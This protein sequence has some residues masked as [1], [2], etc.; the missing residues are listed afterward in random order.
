MKKPD[1]KSLSLTTAAIRTALS[2]VENLITGVTKGYRCVLCMRIFRSML[3]LL[4][5]I[6]LLRLGT[7]SAKKSW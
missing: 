2:H 4:V 7:F 1:R 5:G 6:S 3:R